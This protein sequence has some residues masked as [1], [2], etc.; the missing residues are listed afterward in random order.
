MIFRTILTIMDPIVKN[1][2]LPMDKALGWEHSEN[3]GQKTRP[4]MGPT[5]YFGNVLHPKALSI[6]KHEVNLIMNL[7]ISR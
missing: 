1:L 7:N 2:A 5:L 4:Q 6:I 3:K